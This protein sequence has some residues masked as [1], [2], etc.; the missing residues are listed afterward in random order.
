MLLAGCE[1]HGSASEG[2]A[3]PTSAGAAVCPTSAAEQG[4][5]LESAP[6]ELPF[7]GVPQ[8]RVD[9]MKSDDGKWLIDNPGTVIGETVLV[10]AKMEESVAYYAA[11]PALGD[12]WRAGAN[13]RPLQG[14]GEDGGVC[15]RL[16]LNNQYGGGVFLL[17]V[18]FLDRM[19]QSGVNQVSVGLQLYEDNDWKTLY[20][21]DG[22]LETASTVFHLEMSRDE[23]MV[24]VN[25]LVVGD[26]GELVSGTTDK[27]SDELI[28]TPVIAG[29]GVYNSAA[30]FYA[31]VV[32]GNGR[33]G[34]LFAGFTIGE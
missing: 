3:A 17:T 5:G 22:W 33:P 4:Y 29:F 15:A 9:R 18:N 8:K 12:W 13:V 11:G 26:K 27:I 25:Y 10:N 34:T 14:Y 16:F 28:D 19:E 31:P 30:E 2:T 1:G 24:R 32:E 20:S 6:G 23:S 21:S 7:V